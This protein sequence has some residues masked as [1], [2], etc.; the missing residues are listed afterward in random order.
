MT[1]SEKGSTWHKIIYFFTKGYRQIAHSIII[2]R[3]TNFS[4]V[5][6]SLVI[7]NGSIE[8]CYMYI[9]KSTDLVVFSPVPVYLLE[10]VVYNCYM[11]K[12]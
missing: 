6:F 10:V 1:V 12:T 11:Y 8:D 3:C 4:T 9:E 2:I 7:G 5:A